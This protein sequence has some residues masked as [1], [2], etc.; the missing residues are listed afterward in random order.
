MVVALTSSFHDTRQAAGWAFF[1][2][3]CTI[4]RSR[5][6]PSSGRS[7]QALRLIK[8]GTPKVGVVAFL[9]STR[10]LSHDGAIALLRPAGVR[11]NVP[12]PDDDITEE[13]QRPS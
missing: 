9:M 10:H 6:G 5:G 1:C 8:N 4:S 11:V 2:Y 3:P 13:R 12:T 7:E